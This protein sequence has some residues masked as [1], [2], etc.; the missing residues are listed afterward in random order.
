MPPKHP[1]HSTDLDTKY[2]K[3]FDAMPNAILTFGLH[4]KHFL[5]VNIDFL[6]HCENAFIFLFY[7]MV[8]WT[9]KDCTEE[10]S[11]RCRCHGYIPVYRYRPQDGN[12]VV[13]TA[14]YTSDINFSQLKFGQSLKSWNKSKILQQKYS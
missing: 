7:H 12:D 5:S 10:R 14:V 4:V 11:H 1:A 2:I 8:H 13:C 9:I 3:L 6:Q